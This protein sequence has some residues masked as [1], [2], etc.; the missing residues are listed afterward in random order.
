M[1]LL[2][3]GG[4]VLA[5][6]L[7]TGAIKAHSL[8]LSHIR[9]YGGYPTLSLV[10]ADSAF[11]SVNQPEWP[12]FLLIWLSR[13]RNYE[14]LLSNIP[15][16]S[17]LFLMGVFAKQIIFVSLLSKSFTVAPDR[18]CFATSSSFLKCW[19]WCLSGIIATLN[20]RGKLNRLSD[21][22]PGSLFWP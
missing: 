20:P 19:C 13:D 21:I 9:L 10:V 6:T 14:G 12:K 7:M 2:H 15:G 11:L 5:I 17:S 22:L 18:I 8:L 1:M 4:T 3:S 16:A